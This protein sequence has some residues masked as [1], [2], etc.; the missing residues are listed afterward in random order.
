MDTRISRYKGVNK[1]E[2]S[3]WFP[4]ITN[5]VNAQLLDMIGPCLIPVDILLYNFI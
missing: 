5:I 4:N 2:L 3:D 1:V